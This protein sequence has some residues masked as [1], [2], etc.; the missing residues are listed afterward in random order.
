LPTRFDYFVHRLWWKVWKAAE[1]ETSIQPMV[2]VA[3]YDRKV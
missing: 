1:H 3:I 2:D